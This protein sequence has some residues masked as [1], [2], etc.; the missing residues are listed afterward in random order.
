MSEKE[1]NKI[2]VDVTSVRAP[3]RLDRGLGCSRKR[4]ITEHGMGTIQHGEPRY[5]CKHREKGKLNWAS[6]TTPVEDPAGR[7]DKNRKCRIFEMLFDIPNKG[8]DIL[9]SDR[10]I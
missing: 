2:Y 3:K 10:D 1:Q 6:K 9:C 7:R 5:G 8:R 4:M